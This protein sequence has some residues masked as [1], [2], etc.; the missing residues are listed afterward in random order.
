MKKMIAA[1]NIPDRKNTVRPLRL[2]EKKLLN[3]F[4]KPFVEWYTLRE[5]KY[6]YEDIRLKIKPGVFHPRFFCSTEYMIEF[7]GFVNFS[8]KKVLEIGSGSG[9]ISI[10]AARQGAEVTA[11]DIDPVAVENTGVNVELNRGTI[12]QN[13]GEVRIIESDLFDKLQPGIF[14]LVI[15]NPPFYKGAVTRPSENA[16]YAGTDLQYFRKLFQQCRNHM[17]HETEMYMVLSEDCEL[18]EIKEIATT[19]SLNMKVVSIKQFITENLLIF[20]INIPSN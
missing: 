5:R 17:D 18:A 14:D 7:L 12:A 20:K 3:L 9:L 13:S 10:M 6:T 8:R 11:I 19:N 1:E 4:Y 15:I 2:F 16:W